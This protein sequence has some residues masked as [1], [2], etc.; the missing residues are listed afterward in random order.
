[1]SETVNN[2]NTIVS[3]NGDYILAIADDPA[4]GYYLVKAKTL[5]KLGTVV[6]LKSEK[7]SETPMPLGADDLNSSYP[8]S[9]KP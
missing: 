4:I 8:P 3:Y 2:V 7:P 5:N 9:C 6:A 1:M